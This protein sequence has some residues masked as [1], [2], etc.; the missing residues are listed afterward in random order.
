MEPILELNEKDKVTG[1]IYLMTN[2]EENK[3]YVGQTKSHRKN[4]GK[5]RPF[6]YIGRYNDHISEAI[7]NTKKKQCSYLNNSIRKHGKEKFTIVLI[8]TCD[9]NVLDER[10]QHFISHY[11]TLYPNGYNLTIGGKTQHCDNDIV[12]NAE[13]QN[14]KKRGRAFGYKHSEVT[15]LKM[16]ERLTD[17]NLLDNKKTNMKSVMKSFYDNKKIELLSQYTLDDDI[18][19]YIRPVINKQTKEIHDYIIKIDGRKLTIRSNNETIVQKYE[20]LFNILTKIKE[21]QNEE[22]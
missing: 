18:D 1:Q 2:T 3:S 11:N 21:K 4:K 16:K 14:P 10:E 8:E 12:N 13:L 5:F 7:N 15:I 22:A 9:V 20:R 6:G 19:K 17:K